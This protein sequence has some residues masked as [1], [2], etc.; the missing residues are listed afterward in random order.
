MGKQ[1]VMTRLSRDILN[2][3]FLGILKGIRTEYNFG[4]CLPPSAHS[5]QG[6]SLYIYIYIY[7]HICI[8][9][10]IYIFISIY[11]FIYIYI[12]VYICV[13]IYAYTYVH[14]H[15]YICI[16]MYLIGGGVGRISGVMAG[17]A[18][19]L[20]LTSE[21][22]NVLIA[23]FCLISA[24]T[25]VLV[26]GELAVVIVTAAAVAVLPKGLST[27]GTDTDKGRDSGKSPIRSAIS[28]VT[29]GQSIS[30]SLMFLVTVT[31][32]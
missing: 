20:A 32:P 17:S 29:V 30:I 1:T 4:F 5:K 7:I 2:L 12:Y 25:V 21:L 28:F 23:I 26:E 31:D 18:T 16:Y 6:I 19:V 3:R 10:Y 15:I 14:I 22:F 11:I 27:M 24:L 9:I 13:N 8:Y